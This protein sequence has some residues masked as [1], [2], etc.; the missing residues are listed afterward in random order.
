MSTIVLMTGERVG[1]VVVRVG[2][3]VL[4]VG[5]VVV[6]VVIVVVVVLV[7]LEVVVLVVVVGGEFFP[8][9]PRRSSYEEVTPN[10]FVC[11]GDY[12]VYVRN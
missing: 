11:F 8:L 7:V 1:L 6:V 12:I 3:V 4:R 5:P 2:P 10:P 9:F